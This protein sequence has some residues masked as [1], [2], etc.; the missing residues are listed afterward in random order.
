MGTQER[1]E[2]R[3]RRFLAGLL[4]AAVRELALDPRREPRPHPRTVATSRRSH[5]DAEPAPAPIT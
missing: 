4:A 2:R 5:R 1:R 3:E